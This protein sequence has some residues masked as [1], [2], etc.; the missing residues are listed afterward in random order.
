[1]AYPTSNRIRL[2]ISNALMQNPNGLRFN[3]LLKQIHN[4]QIRKNYPKKLSK[5]TLS[6]YLRLMLDSGEVVKENRLYKVG[7]LPFE[8][9]ILNI[10][11]I[12]NELLR[13]SK[14]I[15][16]YIMESQKRFKSRIDEY[17]TVKGKTFWRTEALKRLK[18]KEMLDEAV[19]PIRLVYRLVELAHK[20]VY[21]TNSNIGFKQL[22][23][24][25]DDFAQKMY[26][27]TFN[28]SIYMINR[29]TVEDLV[30]GSKKRI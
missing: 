28:G 25:S 1:M 8:A 24:D 11:E 2:L 29:S 4:Y 18:Y 13:D 16:S 23:K 5:K 22:F 10:S 21:E 30:F 14:N 6:K 15:R 19:K 27:G 20:L 17:K 12:L 7:V 3:Q 26:I 9:I